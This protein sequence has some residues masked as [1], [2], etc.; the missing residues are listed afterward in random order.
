[1]FSFQSIH[2]ESQLTPQEHIDRIGELHI[3]FKYLGYYPE[4]NKAYKSPF[5]RDSNPSFRFK[6]LDCLMWKCF[7]TGKSGN[8]IN[9]V[10]ELFNI[11]SKQ[12]FIRILNDFTGIKT[13]NQPKVQVT[14][15]FTRYDTEIQVVIQDFNNSDLEYWKQYT[16]AS[17]EDLEF[18][19]IK[20]C[21]EVWIKKELDWMWCWTY[22]KENP[23]YRYRF[24]NRY[25]CYRPKEFNKLYKWLSTT[26]AIDYQGFKQLPSKG[27]LLIITSSYKDVLAWY[28]VGYS[29]VAPSSES[30]IITQK[31]L[32]Y[33]SS[34]FSKIVVNYDSDQAGK[35]ASKKLDLPSIFIPEQESQKDISDLIANKGFEYS[36]KLMSN[37]IS[38]L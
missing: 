17:E 30:Q 20:A 16:N 10:A 18:F 38:K 5:S 15:R 22:S 7:S 11:T 9:L 4:A 28:K 6:L 8:V 26:K 1:M 37:L 2:E 12:A 14:D 25:K 19:N 21:K 24:N 3:Y 33:F 35:K 36:K 32:D 34:R 13:Q 27:D 29:A 23:I 31:H